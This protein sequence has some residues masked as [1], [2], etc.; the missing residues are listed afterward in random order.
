M[1]YGYN[2]RQA[3]LLSRRLFGC[4][5][6][7][8]SRFASSRFSCFDF[9]SFLGFDQSFNRRKDKYLTITGEANR[10]HQCVM[11][12][13]NSA[14]YWPAL[15]VEPALALRLRRA[16]LNFQPQW[17]SFSPVFF[18]GS[19][20]QRRKASNCDRRFEGSVSVP[21]FF[22][23]G[24]KQKLLLWGTCCVSGLRS[25]AESEKEQNE[26]GEQRPRCTTSTLFSKRLFCFGLRH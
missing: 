3:T 21:V 2:D 4:N 13:Q 15:S 18:L 16:V 26:D 8:E 12:V 10:G 20:A 14:T 24:K 7:E 6:R 19:N 11:V 23:F 1:H 5:L 25:W 17:K 22:F 9:C